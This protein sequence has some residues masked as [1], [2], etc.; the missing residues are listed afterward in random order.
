MSNNRRRISSRYDGVYRRIQYLALSAAANHSLLFP[1]TLMIEMAGPTQARIEA[2]KH[3]LAK[4]TQEAPDHGR[5][6]VRECG[7]REEGQQ[8]VG[9]EDRLA[10]SPPQGIRPAASPIELAGQHGKPAR[11]QVERTRL[12][13]WIS[14]SNLMRFVPL[15]PRR[16]ARF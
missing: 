8:G 12:S 15:H 2:V 14:K 5:I 11:S 16:S 1:Y 6:R 13:D 10:G 7:R 3:V 9:V 4:G